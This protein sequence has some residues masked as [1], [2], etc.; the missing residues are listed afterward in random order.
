MQKTFN[1]ILPPLCLKPYRVWCAMQHLC[2]TGPFG[3]NAGP[4]FLL[5]ESKPML[6]GKL[7]VQSDSHVSFSPASEDC[8]WVVLSHWGIHC[9]VNFA[10]KIKGGGIFETKIINSSD[11]DDIYMFLEIL[12]L[13]FHKGD[14]TLGIFWLFLNHFWFQTAAVLQLLRFIL[15]CR[16]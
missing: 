9:Q 4:D 13:T 7:G 15:S 2:L 11:L 6:R 3:W 1:P 16:I 5:F 14:F 8:S 10:K 12:I